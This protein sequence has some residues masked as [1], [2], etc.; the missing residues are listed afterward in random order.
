VIPA[1]RSGDM[2]FCA[3]AVRAIA[4]IKKSKGISFRISI[5]YT[6]GRTPEDQVP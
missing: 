1:A 4:K 6:G 3:E 2:L 5:S